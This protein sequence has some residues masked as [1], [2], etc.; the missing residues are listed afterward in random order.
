[1]PKTQNPKSKIQNPIRASELAQYSF[2]QRA[3]W[4]GVIKKIQPESQANL[5]RGQRAHTRYERRVRQ[6]ARRRQA[7]FLLVGAGSLVLILVLLGF[8]LGGG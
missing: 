5:V 3:W 6:A 2:C 8:W 4:L 7:G 1:V